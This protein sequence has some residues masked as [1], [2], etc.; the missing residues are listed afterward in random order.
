MASYYPIFSP[1]RIG[2]FLPFIVL[3]HHP[4]GGNVRHLLWRVQIIWPLSSEGNYS[5]HLTRAPLPTYLQGMACDKCITS[6]DNQ[7]LIA[8]LFV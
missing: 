2:N 3:C 6:P 8:F 7:G 1:S 5:P 4:V